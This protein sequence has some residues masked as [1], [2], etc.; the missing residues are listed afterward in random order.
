[1]FIK[2]GLLS[3]ILQEILWNSIWPSAANFTFTTARL[4]KDSKDKRELISKPKATFTYLKVLSK[5]CS[6]TI[7]LI[8]TVRGQPT[9]VIICFSSIAFE[10]ALAFQVTFPLAEISQ[11]LKPSVDYAE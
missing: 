5:L 10:V 7:A 4:C 2:S 3:D 6:N 8:Q 11:R 1:V 9:S